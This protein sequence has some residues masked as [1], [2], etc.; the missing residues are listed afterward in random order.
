MKE[1]KTKRSQ[2][3]EMMRDDKG[4]G[5]KHGQGDGMTKGNKDRKCQL[6]NKKTETLNTTLCVIS[7]LVWVGGMMYGLQ[8]I[9]ALAVHFLLGQSRLSTSLLNS[10]YSI[11]SCI[12]APVVIVLAPKWIANLKS[13][14]NKP[15]KQSYSCR[16]WLTSLMGELG[17]KDLPTWTDIGLALVS[18]IGYLL[19]A[20]VFTSFFSI[21]PWFNADETQ[22]VGLSLFMSKP[23][24]VVSFFAVV[25]ITP[26]AEEIIFRGFL[27]GK[28]REKLAE[29]TSNKV[30]IVLSVFLVSLL[31][32][33]MHGQWNVGVNVFA[34]SIVL[35][36][37]RE[38]TG[39]IHSGILLHMLKNGIAFFLVYV[40]GMG[41]L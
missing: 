8:C 3:G 20:L 38:V 33:V 2:D 25:V 40:L 27:Y 23:E 37:L 5:S 28:L 6:E 26:I 11:L 29:A 24:L 17:L 41:L 22:D 32:G 39:T 13:E 4:K 18:Y 9:I 30:S 10:I 19:L 34:L 12:I 7:L 1:D 31:F 16:E 35:C 15:K 21:F 14:P 36:L